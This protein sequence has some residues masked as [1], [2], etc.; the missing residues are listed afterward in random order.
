MS[1]TQD[2]LWQLTDQVFLERAFSGDSAPTADLLLDE[3]KAAFGELLERNVW[4]DS[5]TKV[6]EG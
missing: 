3:V 5:I 4:M 1:T 6:W 2:L